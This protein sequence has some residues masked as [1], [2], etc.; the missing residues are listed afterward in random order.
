MRNSPAKARASGSASEPVGSAKCRTIL[1]CAQP[2]VLMVVGIRRDRRVD[3]WV[4]F[5]LLHHDVNSTLQLHVVAFGNILGQHVNLHVGRDAVPFHFPL[6]MQTINGKA[7]RG[8]TTAVDELGIA[9]DADEAAP[10]PRADQRSQMLIVKVPGHCVT[11][12][13]GRLVDD[14]GLRPE[15]GALEDRS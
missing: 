7:R 5:E 1:F 4:I 14:H 3:D 9:A 13:A 12:R 11:A 2:V 6:A 8:N 10:G 15:D